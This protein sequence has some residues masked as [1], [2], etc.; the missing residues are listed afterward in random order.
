VVL[1]RHLMTRPTI[2]SRRFR[3]IAVSGGAVE[4]VRAESWPERTHPSVE[5]RRRRGAFAGAE[6]GAACPEVV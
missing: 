2:M 3:S 1:S 6:R 4:Q 5:Q